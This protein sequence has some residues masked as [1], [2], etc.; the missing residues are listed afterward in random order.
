MCSLTK[1]TQEI[2]V[3][4]T[5]LSVLEFLA[6]VVWPTANARACQ[7]TKTVSKRTPLRAPPVLRKVWNKMP[8]KQ[9]TRD[10]VASSVTICR[11][12]DIIREQSSLAGYSET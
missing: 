3:R 11:A 4:D 1:Q 5:P 10:H 8:A 9:H 12:S 2:F 7:E 6:E